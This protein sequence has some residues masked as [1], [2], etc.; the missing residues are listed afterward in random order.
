ML[1]KTATF[2]NVVMPIYLLASSCSF[3]NHYND[4]YYINNIL[5]IPSWKRTVIK[6]YFQIFKPF[7]THADVFESTTRDNSTPAV[8]MSDG[9]LSCTGNATPWWRHTSRN[10][11]AWVCWRSLGADLKQIV[12]GRVWTWRDGDTCWQVSPEALSVLL[13]RLKSESESRC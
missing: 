9:V 6:N 10:W 7:I 8:G 12:A 2:L 1:I 3:S 13:S 11:R 4:I 5:G